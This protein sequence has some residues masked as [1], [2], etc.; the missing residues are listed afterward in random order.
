MF[1]S[2]VS[3]GL[4]T[5]I[6]R[7]GACLSRVIGC[8]GLSRVMALRLGSNCMTD[9]MTLSTI[10]R[11]G[12]LSQAVKNDPMRDIDAASARDV[13]LAIDPL[14]LRLAVKVRL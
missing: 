8:D 11:V 14:R 5:F 10:V 12:T 9:V 2:S 7:V 4:T 6:V 13:R 1:A 3:I